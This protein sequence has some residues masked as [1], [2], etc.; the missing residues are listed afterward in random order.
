M[1]SKGYLVGIY[2]QELIPKVLLY[3]PQNKTS[4]FDFLQSLKRGTICSMQIG[5]LP[6]WL[7][8]IKLNG[9]LRETKG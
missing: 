4:P 8:V 3:Y 9:N 2:N 5:F 7:Q 1:I 6:F